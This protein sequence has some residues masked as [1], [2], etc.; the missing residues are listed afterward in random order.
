MTEILQSNRGNAIV[1]YENQ[2]MNAVVN[3]L[4]ILDTK[5]TRQDIN[6]GKLYRAILMLIDA[7]SLQRAL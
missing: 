4:K 5:D 2:L 1:E 3:Q 7:V 6:V